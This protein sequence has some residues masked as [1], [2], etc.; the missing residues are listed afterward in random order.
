MK[1]LA[2]IL[3][4]FILG[5]VF[6]VPNGVD[7]RVQREINITYILLAAAGLYI[8]LDISAA[9]GLLI[10]YTCFLMFRTEPNILTLTSTAFLMILF[11]IMV[12][13]AE[14]WI[15][16]KSL[17]YDA[18][19]VIAGLNFLWQVLQHFHVYWLLTPHNGDNTLTGLMANVDETFAVYM[20]CLPAFFR[21]R[22]WQLTPIAVGGLIFASPLVSSKIPYVVSEHLM[23][24]LEVWKNLIIATK[25]HWLIGWGFVNFVVVSGAE[26]FREAHNE[27]VEW[28]FRG[29]AI[30]I[31]LLFALLWSF[32]RRIRSTPDIL[33]YC[34]VALAC[35]SACAFFIW[36]I[37]SLS[38]LTVMWMT[39]IFAEK[40]SA[41]A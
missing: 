11:A 3:F 23:G 27:F 19:I 30:G 7:L 2:L 16:K 14:Q 29:G 6:I 36:H 8:M 13:T 21:R 12:K 32:A 15:P 10:L 17:I 1:T 4:V 25:N 34:G 37:F 5:S 24:R 39:M 22:R 18:F 35:L 38:F 9:A 26:T 31:I 20:I 40:E 41:L 28:G 33:P